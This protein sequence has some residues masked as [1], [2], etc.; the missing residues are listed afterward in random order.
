[1][2]ESVERVLGV[3]TTM[4]NV[5]HEHGVASF[6]AHIHLFFEVTFELASFGQKLSENAL[7]SEFREG[8]S[9]HLPNMHMLQWIS[10]LI[11]RMTLWQLCS[12]HD[13]IGAGP[14]RLLQT[15]LL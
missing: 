1:M 6:D 14:S 15:S 7:V 4:Y 8:L 9:L 12:G 13:M 3:R 10:Q 5:S 11:V 2:Y